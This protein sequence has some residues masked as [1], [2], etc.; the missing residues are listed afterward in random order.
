[1]AWKVF[2]LIADGTISLKNKILDIADNGKLTFDGSEIPV[3]EGEIVPGEE[4]TVSDEGN[5]VSAGKHFDIGPTPSRPQSPQTPFMYYDTDIKKPMWWNEEDQEWHDARTEDVDIIITVG[6]TVPTMQDAVDMLIGHGGQH[7]Q[8][9]LPDGE[10]SF[11][12]PTRE[13]GTL[14]SIDAVIDIKGIS[15]N[16]DAC[17]LEILGSSYSQW[18]F[19]TETLVVKDVALKNVSEPLFVSFMGD[20][21]HFL[22]CYIGNIVLI[23]QA[24]CYL[25]IKRTDTAADMENAIWAYENSYLEINT[26]NFYRTGIATYSSVDIFFRHAKLGSDDPDNPYSST[27]L[28]MR[29]NST[30]IRTHLTIENADNA[31]VL[32][33]GAH[34]KNAGGITFTNV[35]TKYNIDPSLMYADGTYIAD[36]T[37]MTF[38]GHQGP[39]TGRPT[40]VTIGFDYFDTDIGKPVWWN[41]SDWIDAAGNIV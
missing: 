3:I 30:V 36:G 10:H 5:I 1:M 41:G 38:D 4:L 34:I 28:T 35:G 33:T 31:I 37:P 39:T 17:S 27:I 9:L 7:Y 40:E 19:I 8:I 6:D 24:R 18:F 2:D 16:R 13:D 25:E 15:E 32:Y 26:A 23:P 29:E 22:D 20:E 21:A 12:I 11:Q 14:E